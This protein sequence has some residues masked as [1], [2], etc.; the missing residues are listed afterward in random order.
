MAR[1]HAAVRTAMQRQNLDAIIMQNTSDWVGGYVRW[2]TDQP[3]ANGYPRTVI[4]YAEDPMTCIEMGPFAGDRDLAGKDL[5]RSGAGRILTT[6][7][8]VSI[9]YTNLYHAERVTNDLSRTGAKR[10]GLLAPNGL[11]HG[12][13]RGLENTPGLELSDA[14]DA[15]D[16]IKS[17]KSAEE[18]EALQAVAEL[19]DQAFAAICA[20]IA[21]GMRDIDIAN[22]ARAES[23]KLGSD[24]GIVLG[25]SAPL[26]MSA[27]FMDRGMQGR[28]I[29]KGDHFA[30]LIE[31]NGPSGMYAEIARTMVLGKADGHLR[32][33]FQMMKEAQAH[34]LSLIRPGVAPADVA[35]AHDTWKSEHGIGPELR[36]YAHGQGVDMVER[37]LIRRDETMRFAQDM[38]LAVH[39]AFD[40]G[41]AFSVICDNYMV[42]AEGVGPC[43]HKTE[44]RLF[45]LG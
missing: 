36:L 20:Q 8:F 14:T 32:E 4:F 24:Q 45:E 2:F 15:I 37:P 39:P 23:Q 34:T 21:P 35:E 16:E 43:M 10:V 27:R 30:I 42:E 5:L 40:D 1:R 19:Q 26:G 25:S 41:R 3:A 28:T 22:I 29:K 6:P 9:E 13:M 12:L 38:C 18:I 7:A 31:V 11:P 44:K 17:I 33:G